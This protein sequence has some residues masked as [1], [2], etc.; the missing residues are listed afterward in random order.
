M[1]KCILP[2]HPW[3]VNT[4]GRLAASPLLGEYKGCFP[5]RGYASDARGEVLQRLGTIRST[6]SSVYADAAATGFVLGRYSGVHER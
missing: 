5:S 3:R 1:T 4:V 6:A 2:L